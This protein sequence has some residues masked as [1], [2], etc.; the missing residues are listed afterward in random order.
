M[1]TLDQFI[2]SRR[3]QKI[4]PRNAHVKERGFKILYVRMNAR[5]VDGR[6]WEPALDIA[7]VEASRPGKGAF[8]ALITRLRSQYPDLGIY[9]ETVQNPR[10]C[11]KL[12]SMGFQQMGSYVAAPCFWLPPPT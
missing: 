2:E 5:F 6:V 8:T 12:K 4:W 11:S 10:F 7:S 9:V 3:D 1:Q